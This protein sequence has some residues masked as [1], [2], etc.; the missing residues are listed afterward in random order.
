MDSF[1]CLREGSQFLL[2][3]FFQVVACALVQFELVSLCD[4]VFQM[5]LHVL[6]AEGDHQVHHLYLGPPPLSILDRI[7]PL[8]NPVLEYCARCRTDFS[9]RLERF[10]AIPSRL[11]GCG[12]ASGQ[13]LG[14]PGGWLLLESL[15]RIVGFFLARF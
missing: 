2:R 14:K 4:I 11:H 9:S 6:C 8:L 15:H 1:R 5:L 10:T 12:P 13:A 3:V 7:G